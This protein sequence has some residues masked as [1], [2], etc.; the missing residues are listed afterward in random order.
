MDGKATDLSATVSQLLN[1]AL[2]RIDAGQLDL[3]RE[4]SRKVISTA[5]NC[6]EGYFVSGLERLRRGNLAEAEL[7]IRDAIQL[8]GPQP[9]FL[10][11]LAEISKFSPR[12]DVIQGY[13]RMFYNSRA[14]VIHYLEF[15]VAYA[16]N[17]K[18]KGCTHYSNYNVKGVLPFDEGAAWM[19]QW[20]ARVMPAR[21]RILGGE[22]TINAE[23]CHYIRKAHQ[24]WPKS[25]RELVTNGFFIDRHPDLFQTLAETGTSVQMT[26]HQL[27]QDYLQKSNVER[28]RAA[29][30]E[31][32]FGLT[33]M[34]GTQDDFWQA[35]RGEGEAMM[36]FA[37][38]DYAASYRACNGCPSLAHGR[39]WKCPNTG[40]MRQVDEL[41][42]LSQKPEWQPYTAHQGLTT[43]ASD[44]E[45]LDFLY[46]PHPVCGMC[47]TS[48]TSMSAPPV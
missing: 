35:Y 46:Q 27:D 4:L 12:L 13:L 3:A 45:I 30:R 10:T 37:Q 20:A 8:G 43:Q 40:H 25:M 48:R 32:G 21:F 34:N 42:G 9:V 28:I 5:P 17:L 7:E 2:R 18:C 6:A 1:E 33:V 15:D 22:P 44:K 14:L 39:L 29:S 11:V 16:C 23:L 24:L 26:L 38:G 31:Y 19:E 36:P 47:P 41:F